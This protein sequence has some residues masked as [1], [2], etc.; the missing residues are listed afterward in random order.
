MAW[1][2]GSMF[3]PIPCQFH[4]EYINYIND[5]CLQTLF[6]GGARGGGAILPMHQRGA[7]L[8][9]VVGTGAPDHGGAHEGIG[10]MCDE[11]D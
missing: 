6:N 5:K 9:L 10:C 3:L 11:I 4:G 2:L 1:P 7:A 8:G